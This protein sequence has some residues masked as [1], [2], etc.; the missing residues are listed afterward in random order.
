VQGKHHA[1]P[2]SASFPFIWV[3]TGLK[4]YEI[5][6][7]DL[8]ARLAVQQPSL[9]PAPRAAW[10]RCG[11]AAGLGRLV[12]RNRRRDGLAELRHQR[13]R[14]VVDRQLR[15]GLHRLQGRSDEISQKS[16]TK[17]I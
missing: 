6:M 12:Q 2:A 13:E 16:S 14:G 8:R 3:H 4:G 5:S 11:A 1:G 7:A 9:P 15:R 17:C 10:R